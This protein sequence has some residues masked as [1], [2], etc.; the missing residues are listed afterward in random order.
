MKDILSAGYLLID[1]RPDIINLVLDHLVP[2][3]IIVS[4]MSR[5]FEELTVNTEKWYG[6]SYL[7][8]DIPEEK[9]EEWKQCTIN[10]KF[11]LPKRNK[12]IPYDFSLKPRSEQV[13]I[14]IL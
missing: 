7:I 8:Q 1:F 4:V 9:V 13:L 11:A 6:T 10:E 12:F 14:F 3:K 2:D 5:L